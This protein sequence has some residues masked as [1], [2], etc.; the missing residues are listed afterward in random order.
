MFKLPFAFENFI[1]LFLR[2]GIRQSIDW[3]KCL[4]RVF[5]CYFT[6]FDKTKLHFGRHR[7]NSVQLLRVRVLYVEFKRPILPGKSRY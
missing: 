2:N 4:P 1:S 6:L 5:M 7:R 3:K